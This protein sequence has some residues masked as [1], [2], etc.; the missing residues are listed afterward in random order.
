[1]SPS[2]LERY[3]VLTAR[4]QEYHT[5]A[6]WQEK[7]R[8]L[9]E[10]EKLCANEDLPDSESRT[11]DVLY[12][13]GV[14]RRRLGQYQTAE[15]R[16]Q[17][18][19]AADP[20]SNP[21]KRAHILGELAVV[22]R[23]GGR[24]GEALDATNEQY[25]LARQARPT[26]EADAEQCRAIGNAGMCS[27][28]MASQLPKDDPVAATLLVAAEQQ[29][30]ERVERAQDLQVRVEH[31]TTSKWTATATS[32]ETIGLDRL[33]LVCIAQGRSEQAVR[34]AEESQAK[35]AN[36]D[37]TITA[38]SKFFYGNA[39]WHAGQKIES[40]QQWNAPSGVC[41]SA[42][43]LCKEPSKEH[44]DYLRLM[45]G[46]GVNFDS[47]DEQGYSALD[48]AALDDS[49]TSKEAMSIVL[50]AL[51]VTFSR[52]TRIERSAHA[53][54]Q[55]QALVEEMLESN[56]RQALV[57][58]QYRTLFQESLRPK[59][60]EAQNSTSTA[61]SSIKELRTTYRDFLARL[62]TQHQTLWPFH[63]VRYE[64][65]KQSGRLP[66]YGE[67]F[68]QNDLSID[69]KETSKSSTAEVFVIFFSYRWQRATGPDDSNNTQWQR[70]I[71]AVER[72]LSL[73]PDLEAE[74]I[75]IWLVLPHS[76]FRATADNCT[77]LCLHRSARLAE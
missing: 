61:H 24:F 66:I 56:R 67:G 13:L 64:D 58:R 43:A 27:Y 11:Q 34:V 33:S 5:K 74:D 48:Y 54:D 12:E 57:R 63:Y 51:R 32:W 9:H 60:Q 23:H 39:L 77:G 21:I 28:N 8:L 70:M 17:Q 76:L 49:L 71:D 26:I 62:D 75:A 55:H 59:L 15:E 46:V 3:D 14:I 38:Y 2:V 69:S 22:L 30:Q 45:A 4:A 72:Y 18:A 40:L 29:L 35:Q 19:L 52:K 6:L 1:M 10:L 20:T 44:N 53:E 31:D 37:P 73:N 65:F 41:S 50:D 68:T 42:I 25:D 36:I 16:L 7:L 47:F